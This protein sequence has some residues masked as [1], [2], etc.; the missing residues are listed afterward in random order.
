MIYLRVNPKSQ[1]IQKEKNHSSCSI[2]RRNGT[3]KA[4]ACYH[5]K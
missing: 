4:K 3:F 2:C 5:M 1:N